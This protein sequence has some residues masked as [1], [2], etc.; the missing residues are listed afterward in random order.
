MIALLLTAVTV[1]SLAACGKPFTCDL[2]GEEKTGKKYTET[3]L[4][5]E[6]TYCQDCYKELKELGELLK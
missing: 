1:M 4:G 5:S 3:I 6:I 2:C